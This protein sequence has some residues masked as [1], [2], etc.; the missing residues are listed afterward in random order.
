MRNFNGPPTGRVPAFRRLCFG[1]TLLLSGFC[2]VNAQAQDGKAWAATWTASQQG[3]F[4]EPAPATV[5][6]VGNVKPQSYES[7][8]RRNSLGR[9]S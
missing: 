6:P 1:T 4:A 5:V 7:G 3:V 9:R 8:T 2:A